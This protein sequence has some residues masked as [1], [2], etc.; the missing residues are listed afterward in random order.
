MSTWVSKVH[1]C[2][3]WLH[4]KDIKGLRKLAYHLPRL[5]LPAP[6][7][8]I[9]WPNTHGFHLYIDPTTDTGVEHSLYYDGT[10]EPGTL[11]IIERLLQSGDHFIDVGA[12]IGLMTIFAARLVGPGGKVTAFEP[13]PKTREILLKNI[14]LNGLERTVE[15]L[16]Y[17]LGPRSE[18]GKLYD[19]PG[20]NRGAASLMNTSDAAAIHDIQTI[21]LNDFIE[22]RADMNLPKPTLIKIDVEGF[23]IEVLNGATALI[24]SENPPA[25]I[26]E[27]SAH[28][29]HSNAT[30]ISALYN[31]LRDKPGYKIYKGIKNKAFISSLKMVNRADQMPNHDNVYV[32]QKSHFERLS[33]RIKVVL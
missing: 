31:L 28:R 14:A 17:A 4:K 29:D 10:Y 7:G 12:N 18:K 16:P 33:G 32:L 19:D 20:R 11:K 21:S 23:E 9:V 22:S 5:L 3:R 6:K 2:A 15:V 25:L 30:D 8:S 24:Q 1:S 27:S 26:V 13:H